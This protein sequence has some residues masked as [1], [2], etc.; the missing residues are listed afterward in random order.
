M[1]CAS[2]VRPRWINRL[3]PLALQLRLSLCLRI[4]LG[5]GHTHQNSKCKR[6]KPSKEEQEKAKDFP[7]LSNV[8]Q[9]EQPEPGGRKSDSDKK[10][11]DYYTMLGRTIRDA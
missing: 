5:H 9:E 6:S 10:A 7:S 3:V 8:G 11:D 1:T 4:R 2:S